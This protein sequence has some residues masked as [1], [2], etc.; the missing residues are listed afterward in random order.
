MLVRAHVRKSERFLNICDSY[1]LRWVMMNGHCISN[2]K[3][4][5][6]SHFTG[7]KTQPPVKITRELVR[8]AQADDRRRTHIACERFREC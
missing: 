6:Q 8:L 5:F 2:G 3:S 1:R 4:L 7:L